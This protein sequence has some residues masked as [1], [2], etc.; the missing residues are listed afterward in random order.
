MTAD[1]EQRIRKAVDALT[2]KK[3]LVGIPSDAKQ[4]AGTGKDP[5]PLWL[6]GYINEFG[7]ED[8]NIPPRP[9][10]VP[11]VESVRDDIVKQLNKGVAGAF[12]GDLSAP[13]KAMHAAGLVAQAAVKQR[14][15]EGPF[16]PLKPAT[17]YNRQHR[18]DPP[19]NK[20]T[21]P[22]IDTRALFNAVNYAVKG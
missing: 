19:P 15:I 4:P 17:I 18:K 10:L 11:G 12:T 14:L 3:L 8:L 21:A 5:P 20:R 2:R 13:D 22:L 7:D 6:I 1:L 9:F 16:T